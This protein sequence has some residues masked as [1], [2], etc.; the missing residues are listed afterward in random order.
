MIKRVRWIE[1][2]AITPQQFHDVYRDA[3]AAQQRDAVPI[4]FWGK[5]QPHICLGVHQSRA[6][7]LDSASPHPI[8]RR[9]LGGGTVWL[10]PRQYCFIFVV[11]AP[12]WGAPAA[13]FNSGLAPLIDTYRTFGLDVEQRGRDVWLQEKKIAGSG[14]ATIGSSALLAS[15][16]ILD[17]DAHSFAAAIRCPSCQYRSMLRKALS[18]AMTS[19]QVHATPPAESDIRA[20]FRNHVCDRFGWTVYADDLHTSERLAADDAD[21][22]RASGAK[23]IANG[24]KIN[25]ATFLFEAS[26]G[27]GV[28]T[29]LRS[30][31]TLA[32]VALPGIISPA[33]A[34]R[35]AGLLLSEPVLHCALQQELT[36][37]QAAVW[38]RRILA[39]AGE[40]S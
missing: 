21:E 36:A 2:G 14:A 25:E 37:E 15:S 39:L 19:W 26:F 40:V 27:E 35:M 17:F 24:I 1:I 32:D 6:A 3:A 8:A 13:W 7:E 22:E 10:D 11:P 20:A 23:T 38:T 12:T 18:G 4:I 34:E 33:L 5:P 29:L 9:S 16:F 30:H 31:H 28:L